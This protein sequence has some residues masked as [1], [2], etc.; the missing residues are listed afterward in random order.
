MLP[1]P[2]SVSTYGR[3]GGFHNHDRAYLVPMRCRMPI[4]RCDITFPV[5]AD[6]IQ[7]SARSAS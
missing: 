6:D 3:G 4:I 5:S 1:V 2:P 7:Y